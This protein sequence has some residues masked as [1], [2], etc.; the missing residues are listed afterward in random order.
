MITLGFPSRFRWCYFAWMLHKG[1]NR[2]SSR[3]FFFIF[4]LWMN[5][6]R[7][8]KHA[9]RN[10]IE[11]K[12]DIVGWVLEWIRLQLYIFIDAH[13]W[14][15]DVKGRN[16]WHQYSREFWIPYVAP[17]NN[18]ISRVFFFCNRKSERNLSCVRYLG[19]GRLH[20]RCHYRSLESFDRK[21]HFSH[22]F[23]EKSERLMTGLIKLQ[24]RK[25][26]EEPIF[27]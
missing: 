25:V 18:S 16:S 10:E 24:T 12:Q 17:S 9:N 14:V 4:F 2:A 20:K 13:S 8:E 3:V 1:Q 15:R 21:I 27:F 7:V 11:S 26:F 23:R 22:Q 19:G 6:L 5:L